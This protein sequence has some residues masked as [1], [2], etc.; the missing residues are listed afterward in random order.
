[1]TTDNRPKP[2]GASDWPPP[3]TRCF[4]TPPSERGICVTSW[5]AHHTSPTRAWNARIR[6]PPEGPGTGNRPNPPPDPFRSQPVHPLGE[7]APHRRTEVSLARASIERLSGCQGRFLLAP[8]PKR[9]HGL[10]A[11]AVGST[12]PGY[13]EQRAAR[14]PEGQHLTNAQSTTRTVSNYIASDTRPTSRTRATLPP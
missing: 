3:E 11:S 4:Q 5:R 6:Y 8:S 14:T 2:L 9:G 10:D 12:L 13:T 7:T 1:M